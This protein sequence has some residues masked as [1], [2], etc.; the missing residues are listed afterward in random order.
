M[1]V[2]VAVQ[3]QIV[4]KA[5]LIAY[6]PTRLPAGWRFSA[7]YT[8][9]SML[10]IVFRR[11]GVGEIDFY[12]TP[13]RG[14]CAA[15]S[16]GSTGGVFWNRTVTQQSAWRCVGGRKLVA[17]T[18]LTAKRFPQVALTRFVASARRLGGG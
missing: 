16:L 11:A 8:T 4:G 2:P 10:A 5:P 18:L 12:V 15:G 3:Q 17:E 14:S 7:W 13:Y 9:G 1:L 6:A